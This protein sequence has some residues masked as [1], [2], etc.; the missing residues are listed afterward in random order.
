MLEHAPD[1]SEAL[2]DFGHVLIGRL[3]QTK[4]AVNAV[5][6]EAALP[7]WRRRTN[8]LNARIWQGFQN[9]NPVTLQNL[10]GIR[11]TLYLLSG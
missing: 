10:T 4:L 8:H 1:F 11:H 5:I 2:N 6:S 3:L 7:V 9:L